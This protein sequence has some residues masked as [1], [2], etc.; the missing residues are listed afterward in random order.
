[1]ALHGQWCA[2]LTTCMS[3]GVRELARTPLC[4]NVRVCTYIHSC[5]GSIYMSGNVILRLVVTHV[6]WTPP[7]LPMKGACSPQVSNDNIKQIYGHATHSN[8]KGGWTYSQMC[9]EIQYVTLLN[10]DCLQLFCHPRLK[11]T[12]SGS[13]G[14]RRR[15]RKGYREGGEEVGGLRES[16]KETD[17]TKAK[18]I[19][20]GKSV[21]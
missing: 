19:R 3:P 14:G 10:I 2:H 11:R 21:R 13:V 12:D 17:N 4:V 18:Y 8:G 15:V 9:W 16:K 6:S 1:M 5:I 20:R 7:A